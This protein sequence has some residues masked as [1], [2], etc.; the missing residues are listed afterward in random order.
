MVLNVYYLV[1]STKPSVTA[2]PRWPRLIFLK[3]CHFIWSDIVQSIVNTGPFHLSFSQFMYLVSS[4]DF[5]SGGTVSFKLQ[6]SK[7]NEWEKDEEVIFLE[8]KTRGN[9]ILMDA[10]WLQAEAGVIIGLFSNIYGNKFV[11]KWSLAVLVVVMR[12]WSNAK[13]VWGKWKLIHHFE[14]RV[15]A[16]LDIIRKLCG[17]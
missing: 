3:I 8:I 2:P 10:S 6:F 12:W 14:Q 15:S 16:N 11:V 4:L 13:F 5:A 17:H 1:P 9:D 7:Q